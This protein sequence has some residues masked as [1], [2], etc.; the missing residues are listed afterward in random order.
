LRTHSVGFVHNHPGVSGSPK[1]FWELVEKS[2]R[3]FCPLRHPLL[4]LR[5]WSHNYFSYKE[6]WRGDRLLT[7]V[8]CWQYVMALHKIRP[9]MEFVSLDLLDRRREQIAAM[10]GSD[11]KVNWTAMNA[12]R[13][14]PDSPIHW[15]GMLRLL[16]TPGLDEWIQERGYKSLYKI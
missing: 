5:T 14:S 10:V 11:E 2:E 3:I 4:P 16:E 7:R 13:A 12:S 6:A 8:D 9:D 15:E 1:D